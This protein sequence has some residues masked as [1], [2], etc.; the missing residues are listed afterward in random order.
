MK[1]KKNIRKID[2]HNKNNSKAAG[3]SFYVENNKLGND[4]LGKKTSG[5]DVQIHH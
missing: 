4:F 3:K 1:F 2:N 5:I